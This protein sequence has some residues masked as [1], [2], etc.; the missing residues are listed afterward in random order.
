V[1]AP[2]KPDRF[3]VV[4]GLAPMMRRSTAAARPPHSIL[5][6]DTIGEL[7]RV[8]RY[9]TAAFI[10]GSLVPTGGHNPIEAAA[11]GV[12]V[13]FGP[14]MSNFREIAAVFL[15]NDAAVE[16]KSAGGVVAFARQMALQ[17]GSIGERARA[18]VEQNRGA[19]AKTAQRI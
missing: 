14:H 15:E 3:D 4:A 5:L 10:G 11:A 7:A 8:Y 13:S 1:V 16:V 18:T 9:A 17:P 6:L 12:P 19:A 2:R